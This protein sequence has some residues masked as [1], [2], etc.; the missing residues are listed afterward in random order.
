VPGAT[1]QWKNFT[2]SIGTNSDTFAVIPS[3]VNSYSC[4]ITK[5]AGWCFS[6]SSIVS[7]SIIVQLYPTTTPNV[8]IAVN[9]NPV[10]AGKSDTVVATTNF[11][12]GT[13]QW[14]VNG[15][16]TGSNNGIHIFTPANN[17]KVKLV[18]TVPSVAPQLGCYSPSTDTSNEITITTNAS[19]VPTLSIAGNTSICQGTSTT[20]TATTNVTGGNYQWKVNGVNTGVNAANHNYIPANGDVVSC[21][22][23]T[24]SSPCYSSPTV[25]SNNLSISVTPKITPTI[26]ISGPAQMSIGSTVNLT[27]TLTGAGSGYTI[28]WV[29]N[30]VQLANTV[31]PN[32]SYTKGPGNDNIFAV[33]R[34]SATCADS[35]TSVTITVQQDLSVSNNQLAD[36]I[37]IYPNPVSQV[38]YADGLASGDHVTITGID[39]R[40]TGNTYVAEKQQQQHAIPVGNLVPG[41]YIISIHSAE[42]QSKGNVR[43]QKL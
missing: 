42:G 41:T 40:K 43:I 31:V 14:F 10:C 19:T 15:S 18:V 29:K 25:A 7:N 2:T 1:Y 24:P 21:V 36:G 23:T 13:Y 35:A 16:P 27:A 32:T 37:S 4:T 22:V 34:P 17:D 5:A 3:G 12:G 39:G 20:Y 38:I 28:R 33:V 6:P 26:S 9:T 8:T 30:S 11:T